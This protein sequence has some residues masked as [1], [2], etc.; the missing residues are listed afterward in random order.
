MPIW[1][2]L[3][4]EI[5]VDLEDKQEESYKKEGIIQKQTQWWSG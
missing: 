5:K 2:V 4:I 3:E 1:K